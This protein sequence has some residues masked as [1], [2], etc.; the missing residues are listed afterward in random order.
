MCVVVRGVRLVRPA[1]I[2]KSPFFLTQ[3]MTYM[4]MFMYAVSYMYLEHCAC[5]CMHVC[6]HVYVCM[7]VHVCVHA[8]VSV[9]M[10]VC[11]CVCV[12]VCICCIHTNTV[13]D[14]SISIS[15]FLWFGDIT[16]EVVELSVRCVLFSP[17]LLI[18]LLLLLG[19]VQ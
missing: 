19:K 2:M 10:C 9:C 16:T 13:D 1:A 12:C 8:C 17:S 15:S 18:F 3:W 14:N 6:V 5:T 4:Y 7:C 11:V